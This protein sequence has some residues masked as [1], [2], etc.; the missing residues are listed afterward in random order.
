[1]TKAERFEKILEEPFE[2]IVA[3]KAMKRA[4]ASFDHLPSGN[5]DHGRFYGFCDSSKGLLH[6]LQAHCAGSL[7][8]CG[9]GREKTHKKQADEYH[10]THA[11][12]EPRSSGAV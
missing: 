1:M 5:V 8:P 7:A 10:S 4:G 12:E 6:I 3:F 2:H 11:A 9:G